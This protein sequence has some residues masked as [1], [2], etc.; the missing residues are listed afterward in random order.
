MIY[1]YLTSTQPNNVYLCDENGLRFGGT[2]TDNSQFDKVR[3]HGIFILHF[4]A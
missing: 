3:V 2:G 4:S 1:I